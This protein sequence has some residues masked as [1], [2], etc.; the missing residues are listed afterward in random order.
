MGGDLTVASEAG[1]GTTFTVTLPAE[2]QEPAADSGLLPTAAGRQAVET[3][4]AAGSTVLVIDDDPNARDLMMRS[5][6]KDGFRVETA[7]DG[8]AGLEIAARLKPDVIT[9]DVMMPGMS[10]WAVLK[11]LKANP[12]TAD[13]PVVMVS[14][15]DDRNIGYTLGASDYLTKPLDW[16][17][18]PSLLKR[19]SRPADGGDV[20]VVDDDP[21]NREMLRRMLEREGWTV[22]EAENGRRALDCVEA[23]RPSMILLDLM[24]PEMDGFAFMEEFRKHPENRMVPVIVVTA[25]DLTEEDH[26]RLTG[27]VASILQKGQ[28][29]REDLMGEVRQLLKKSLDWSI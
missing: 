7:A 22:V 27:Q 5:L 4:A 23:A 25:K 16:S 20:L 15:V 1:Q 14:M 29:T 9:L 11:T 18:L 10:G 24:M 13:I 3:P 6:C 17:R 26:R 28:T 2:V 12:V 19:H 8:Q 21:E